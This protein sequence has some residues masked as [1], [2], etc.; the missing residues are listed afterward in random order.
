M[1]KQ[2]IDTHCHLEMVDYEKDRDV[3]I[4]RAR[5]S[6]IEYIINAGSDIQGNIKGLK[7]S[8][9]YP[10][11]YPAVGI[12]PHDAKT[13]NGDVFTEIRNWLKLPK[14]IAIGEIGLDYHYLH[15]PK[16]IQVDAFRRQIALAKERG[17]PVIV[18]SREAKTDTLRVLR[19]EIIDTT[20]VLHCFSGDLD[21]A[22]KAMEL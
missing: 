18:H 19:E 6:G 1:Q 3:I 7:I 16:G 8:N 9:I 12:H 14:V 17:L 22:K 11:V 15:S 20:G 2:L 21:M 10:E 4:R 5:Q 13:L